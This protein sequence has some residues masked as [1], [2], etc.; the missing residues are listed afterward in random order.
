MYVDFRSAVFLKILVPYLTVRDYCSVRRVN[1]S[2]SDSKWLELCGKNTKTGSYTKY[3]TDNTKSIDFQND[4][5]EL[6][7]CPPTSCSVVYYN[8]WYGILDGRYNRYDT[9]NVHCNAT[10]YF[11][12]GELMSD[13]VIDY[14]YQYYRSYKKNKLHGI[15]TE[16]YSYNV[17]RE[18]AYDMGRK[19]GPTIYYKDNMPTIQVDYFNGFYQTISLIF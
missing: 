1:K 2:M 17:V 13:Y 11:N 19:H 7:F 6:P 15:V 18:T 9:N 8:L 5:M 14:P 12:R 3:I 4:E 10:M 16:L